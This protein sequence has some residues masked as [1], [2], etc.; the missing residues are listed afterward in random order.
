MNI[1]PA[2]RAPTQAGVATV[3]VAAIAWG[4]LVAQSAW[5][6]SMGAMSTLGAFVATWMVMMTAMMLPAAVPFVSGFVRGTRGRWPLEA[7]VLVAVYLAVWTAFGAVAHVL[8]S[9]LPP[10]WMDQRLVAG[11]AIV[12][13]GLYA[14]TPIQRSFQVRCH[15][16]CAEPPRSAGAGGLEYGMSCV[17]CSWALM[18]ALLFLG[19]SNLAW[20]VAAAGVVLVYKLAPPRPRWQN[21]AAIALLAAGIGVALLPV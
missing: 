10:A 9:L 3:I 12:A 2:D 14:F 6:G 8:Y 5:V 4:V 16:M 21:T 17:G 20:M 13:A 15:A 19:I 11:L 7:A 1:S 18:V